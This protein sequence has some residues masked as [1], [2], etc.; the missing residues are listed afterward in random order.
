MAAGGVVVSLWWDD[1]GADATRC[2]RCERWTHG[3][4]PG[5]AMPKRCAHCLPALSLMQPYAGLIVVDRAIAPRK[6]IEN[7]SRIIFRPPAGGMWIALHASLGFY[8]AGHSSAAET[9]AWA[10]GM[11]AVFAGWRNVPDVRGALLGMFHVSSVVQFE[12]MPGRSIAPRAAA[13]LGPQAFGPVCYTIDDARPLAEPI[14]CKGAMGLWSVPV[15]CEAPLKA[16]I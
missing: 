13:H 2:R 8:S 7:R 3:H 5:G 6:V 4:G 11:D 14:P 1:A 16:L 10:A 12:E 15:V 9:D